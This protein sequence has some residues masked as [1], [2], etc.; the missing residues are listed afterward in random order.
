MTKHKYENGIHLISNNE[1]HSSQGVSRSA[2]WKLKRSPAHY[3][4]EYLNPNFVKSNPTPDMVL[5]SLVHTLVLEPEKF[6][7]EYAIKPVAQPLPPVVRLKDVGRELFDKIKAEREIVSCANELELDVFNTTSE[8]KTIVSLE[9][10]EQAQDMARAVL[11]DDVAKSLLDGANVEHS[12]YWTH[13]HTGLQVKCRPDCFLGSVVTDLK[14]TRDA[15]FK[16][17][18]SDAYRGGYFLQAGMMYKGLQSIGIT[19]EK[20]VFMCVEKTAP[21]AT[22]TYILDDE[23]IDY[24]VNLFDELMGKLKECCDQ[25]RWPAYSMQTLHVPNW[26]KYDEV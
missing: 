25:D 9:T 15:S 16:A 13:E 14:T 6:D 3:W 23:A 20:F 12:I 19:M 18:Q 26:A 24:G 21:Y 1:Y 5:G 2:L 22:A 17:F 7:E 4:H 11:N 10:Y 8:G